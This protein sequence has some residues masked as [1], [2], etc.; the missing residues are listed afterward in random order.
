MGGMEASQAMTLLQSYDLL[1]VIA[2]LAVL[3]A[4][5]LPRLLSDKPLSLAMVLLGLGFS[6]FALPLGLEAPSPLEHGKLTERLTEFA[7]IIAL[8][9]AGLKLD[10]PPG[11]RAW[12]STWRLLAIT[13]PLTIVAA[14]VLGW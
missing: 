13:M 8:M 4:A 9:G 12:M 7:V 3:A 14:A 11:W 1:L 6:A 2:G 10:R 5:V